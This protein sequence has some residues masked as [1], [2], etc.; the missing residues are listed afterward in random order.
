MA[1]VRNT[2][3]QISIP[4]STIF[5]MG[6]R[7]ELPEPSKHHW[8]RWS[9]VLLNNNLEEEF[10]TKA[11]LATYMHTLYHSTLCARYVFS[12]QCRSKEAHI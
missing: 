8:E 11:P 12:V 2:E 3:R 4:N 7:L 1:Q 9:A 6:Q 5:S 10:L